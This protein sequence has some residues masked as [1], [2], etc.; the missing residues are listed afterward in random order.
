MEIFEPATLQDAIVYFSSPDNCREYLVAHRWPDGVTCPRCGSKNVLFQ[1]KY[2]RWQCGSKHDLRQFTSKTGTIFEDSPL[3]LD[4]WLLAMWQVVNCKNG[5]SSYEIHRAVGVTQKTAWFMDHRIRV[6]LGMATPDKLTGHVEADE[7]FVGGKARNMHAH[8]RTRKITGTGGKDKT[9]VMGILERGKDGKPSQL[10]TKVVSNR[11]KKALQAEVREHVQAGSAIYTDAL[12]SY[13]GLDEFEHEVVDHA[14]EYVRG[15]VHTN[16]CENFWSLLKRGL[17]GTYVSVE[18]FQLFRY[19]DEQT[20]RFN[21]RKLTDGERFSVAV[22]GIVGKRLTF[23]QLT[24]KSE[25]AAG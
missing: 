5:V 10:R 18:P 9:M 15:N 3:S 16:G 20:F 25:L 1:A 4:K 23:D 24:G 8:I 21:N 6:A 19:L 22:D 13:E 2:N 12:K 14:V 11:R 7:T 17:H